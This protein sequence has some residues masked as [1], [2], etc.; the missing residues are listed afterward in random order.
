[1]S[2]SWGNAI[3][4][5]DSAKD[6][7]GKIMSLRDELIITYFI[8]CTR[9][10]QVEIKKYQQQLKQGINPRDI[11]LILAETI[12]VMYNGKQIAQKESQQFIAQFS[13]GKVPQDMVSVKFSGQKL[14]DLLSQHKIITS[15]SEGRRLLQQG[16][17]RINQQKVDN[18]NQLLKAGDIIQVGKRK[19]L[20]LK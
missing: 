11:K 19:F 6:M 16:G 12:V 3:N 10:P 17:I 8:H 5:T 2:S 1:M 15:R 14:L 7:F 4:L 18:E 9:V 20:R 13:Q